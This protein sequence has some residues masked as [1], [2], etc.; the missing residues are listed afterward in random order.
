M[1]SFQSLKYVV[2][3][4]FTVA[5][6][7]IQVQVSLAE[8]G[9]NEVFRRLRGRSLI[10]A[11]LLLSPFTFYSPTILVKALLMGHLSESNSEPSEDDPL[12]CLYFLTELQ[13][14]NIDHSHDT[15]S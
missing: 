5:E 15:A 1:T 12:P 11:M 9:K 6:K 13:E 14:L 2:Q 8:T 3:S 7:A 10:R 4:D